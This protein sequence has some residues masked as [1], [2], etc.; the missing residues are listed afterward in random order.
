M[1]ASLLRVFCYPKPSHMQQ[2]RLN[3]FSISPQSHSVLFLLI[4]FNFHH[5]SNSSSHFPK[6][7]THQP[8][9]GHGTDCSSRLLRNVSIHTQDQ[10]P[11]ERHMCHFLFLDAIKEEIEAACMNMCALEDAKNMHKNTH[12]HT[13]SGVSVYMKDRDGEI[14]SPT[15]GY[16]ASGKEQ[17]W[18]ANWQLLPKQRGKRG[19]ENHIYT[20][21]LQGKTV[22]GGRKFL[23]LHLEH[24]MTIL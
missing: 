23:S 7:P 15:D 6:P 12:T 16:H 3:H 13:H 21:W 19:K 9:G 22:E 24:L 17:V 2:N 4:N 14:Q 8:W 18:T 1:T 10:R 20:E 5:F 11:S